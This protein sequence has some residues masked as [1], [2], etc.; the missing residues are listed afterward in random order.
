MNNDQHADRAKPRK[1][2]SGGIA[3]L[4]MLMLAGMARYCDDLGR[5]AASH[6]DDVA[7]YADE[8]GRLSTQADDAA[9]VST[10]P[11]ESSE[12]IGEELRGAAGEAGQAVAEEALKAAKDR[13]PETINGA[14][15]RQL[16]CKLLQPPEILIQR[17]EEFRKEC[18]LPLAFWAGPNA[19]QS[20]RIE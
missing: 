1:G 12:A 7:N 10:L 2:A 9:R 11:Q 20:Q 8:L 6:V 16:R 5:V 18:G 19:T 4:L 13:E 3:G 17:L 14:D 15:L